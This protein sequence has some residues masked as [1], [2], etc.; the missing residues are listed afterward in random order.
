MQLRFCYY[1]FF[2]VGREHYDWGLFYLHYGSLVEYVFYKLSISVQELEIVL[3]KVCPNRGW[4]LFALV[5]YS[6]LPVGLYL[7]WHRLLN[8]LSGSGTL[9]QEKKTTFP[10]FL[11]QIQFYF[12]LFVAVE[13]WIAAH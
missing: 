6:V 10:L 3:S 5:T 1:S 7:E 2:E 9:E 8:T 11:G 4:H 13:V 12:F